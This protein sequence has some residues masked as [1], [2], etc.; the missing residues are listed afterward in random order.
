MKE[1]RKPITAE[2]IQAGEILLFFPKT[3]EEAAEI[4]HRLF[5]LGTEW[6][7]DG[8]N[9]KHTGACVSFGMAVCY[10]ALSYD[11]LSKIR[12][13]GYNC[14][15]QSLPPVSVYNPKNPRTRV[16]AAAKTPQPVAAPAKNSVSREEFEEL[17]EKFNALIAQLQIEVTVPAV[18]K[19][20]P[21]WEH[22]NT[23]DI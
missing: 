1:N 21:K 3:E 7:A 9:I 16:T 14:T 8:K 2:R 6:F 22:P 18:T 4:Q 5:A 17:K 12:D 23:Y 20:A 15:I 10:A 13:A 11:P 19:P